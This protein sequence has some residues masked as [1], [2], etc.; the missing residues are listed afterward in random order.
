MSG[1]TRRR[2]KAATKGEGILEQHTMKTAAAAAAAHD[3]SEILEQQQ[4]TREKA[5]AKRCGRNTRAE[6]CGDDGSNHR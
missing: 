4:I 5:A 6:A 1:S 2:Q 3:E